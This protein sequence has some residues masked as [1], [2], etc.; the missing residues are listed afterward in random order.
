MP[1]SGDSRTSVSIP[2]M[3]RV[4]GTT[5]ISFNAS[6]TSSRVR[7]STGRRLSGAANMYHRISPRRIELV[8]ALSLPCQGL[9]LGG[10]LAPAGRVG[11]IGLGIRTAALCGCAQRKLRQSD[12][13]VVGKFLH[14][15]PEIF[16]RQHRVH[17]ASLKA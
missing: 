11:T 2:R 13:L 9:F 17:R 10:D 12:L 4:A 15:R 7:T 6:M 1:S 16:S 8:P 3:V 5:M 14:E